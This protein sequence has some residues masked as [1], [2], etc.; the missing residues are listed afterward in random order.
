MDLHSYLWPKRTWREG[1]TWHKEQS[2]RRKRIAK[3]EATRAR[4]AKWRRWSKRATAN[5]E[6]LKS[7]I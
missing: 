3:L 7:L 4:R 2:L 5:I 1:I 6:R